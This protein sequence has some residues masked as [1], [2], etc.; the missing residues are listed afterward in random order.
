MFPLSLFAGNA[1][2]CPAVNQPE[3][4]PIFPPGA[5]APQKAANYLVVALHNPIVAA[6]SYDLGLIRCF[7]LVLRDKSSYAVKII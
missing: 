6:Y 1:C 3:S 4:A 7:E 2:P 5:C